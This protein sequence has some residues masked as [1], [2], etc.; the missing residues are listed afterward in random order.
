MEP[1][2]FTQ[3]IMNDHM[4][5]YRQTPSRQRKRALHSIAISFARWFKRYLQAVSSSL[6]HFR[7]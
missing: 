3:T 2:I 4:A 5:E 7:R 6:G 1:Y